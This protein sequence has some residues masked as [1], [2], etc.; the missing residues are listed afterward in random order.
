[1]V[2]AAV[3]EHDYV[4]LRGEERRH[5]IVVRRTARGIRSRNARSGI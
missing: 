1:M 2:V 5:F 3:K 4:F